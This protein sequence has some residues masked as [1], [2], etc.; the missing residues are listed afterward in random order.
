MFLPNERGRI[1]LNRHTHTKFVLSAQT[2]VNST[3]EKSGWFSLMPA[4][5]AFRGRQ[6]PGFVCVAHP[7]MS[8]DIDLNGTMMPND[9]D[10]W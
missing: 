3:V 5:K 7:P 2:R 6:I 1:Y 10:K 8:F 9:K 4:A